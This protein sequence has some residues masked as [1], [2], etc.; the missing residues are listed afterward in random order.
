MS[1]RVEGEV[2][3]IDVID[4]GVSPAGKGFVAIGGGAGV[5]GEGEVFPT[6]NR[7]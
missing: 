7:V 1:Y 6:W 4:G 3:S 5:V 2:K